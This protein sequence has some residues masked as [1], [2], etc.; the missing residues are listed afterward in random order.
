MEPDA[1]M[2]KKVKVAKI[3][4]SAPRGGTAQEWCKCKNGHK[5]PCSEKVCPRCGAPV[6]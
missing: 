5:V 2:G 3:T 6:S 1:S 4:V